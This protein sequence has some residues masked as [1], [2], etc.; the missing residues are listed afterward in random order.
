MDKLHF[1]TAGIPLRSKPSNYKN[2]FED[3]IELGLDGMELEFVHG[4]R[5]SEDSISTVKAVTAENNLITTA[6]AP[7]YINLNSPEPKKIDASITRIID[8]A[9]TAA[10]FDAYSITYHA[11]YYMKKDENEVYKL[12][13]AANELIGKALQ[14][15]NVKIWVRPETTGKKSQWGDIFEVVKLSKDFDFV[16]PCVDFSHLHAREN[17]TLKTYDDFARILEFMGNELGQNALNNFHAHIAGIEY[18]A[19]GERRHLILEESDMNYKDL[20]KAFVNFDVKGVVVCE[21]PNIEDDALL[22]KE[23]YNSIL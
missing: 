14:E 1:L 11:A 16:L 10:K 2:G 22:I 18:S 9:L 8:T 19:K 17:G 3:I 23:F 12:I 7:F 20:L 21:S 15:S 6:H 13:C 5:I 4:V